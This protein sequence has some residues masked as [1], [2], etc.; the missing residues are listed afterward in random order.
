VWQERR[1]VPAIVQGD[2]IAMTTAFPSSR[3]ALIFLVAAFAM[4]WIAWGALVALAQ[5]QV[6]SYGQWPYMTLYVLGGLGPTI[7]AY[8]AV[9]FTRSRAPLREFHRRLFR[10]RVQ[11]MWYVLAI[12]LP[13]MLAFV[14]I[15]IAVALRPALAAE[16]TIKPWYMFPEL[17]A[18][19]IIGGGLEE[20]GWRGITQEEWGQAIGH[21]RAALLIG[22]IWALWHLPLFFLPGVTQ[23]HAHFSL[24][25]VGIMGNSLLFGWLYSRR[26][27]ILLCVFIHAAT[28]ATIMLGVVVPS[29]QGLSLI[30]P[31]LTIAV[32]ALLFLSSG[33]RRSSQLDSVTD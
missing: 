1:L 15:G 4:T 2:V 10:W 5:A 12:G 27:S 7:A 21:G 19:T 29:G 11:P 24:F 22:P 16:V 33:K 3:R 13:I 14:A 17:F 8:I 23:Y 32:G 28:N 9:C 25:L 6:T 26:R 18:M 30:G 20:L 31:C